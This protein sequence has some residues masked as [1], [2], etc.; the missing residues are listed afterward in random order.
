[1]TPILG[2]Y[3]NGNYRVYLYHDGTKVRVNNEDTMIPDRAESVDLN[4]TE[5]CKIV[6][7]QCYL[8]CTPSGKH[9]KLFNEDGS[10]YAK[11]LETLPE[12][13]EIAINGND[14][15]HPQL[16]MFLEYCKNKK[17]IVNITVHQKQFIDNYD[18]LLQLKKERLIYGIGVSISYLNDDIISKLKSIPDV[19]CH[20]I[21]G[22]VERI[23]FDKL[24]ENNLNILIL[25]YKYKGRGKKYYD[26]EFVTVINNINWLSEHILSYIEKG[27][28]ISFDCLA[29]EQMKMK[30][31]LS[32][33]E[34]KQLYMGEDGTTTFYVDAVNGKFAKSSTEEILHDIGNK[35]IDEMFKFIT[36]KRLQME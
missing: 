36:E 24:I 30:G 20:V 8:G 15:D 2:T 4:F 17:C 34:W 14:M 13:I 12:Y 26:K 33:E 3:K 10:I 6:C 31:K 25:G 27:S 21:A 11:W 29:C 35:S 7:A 5:K 18:L 22:I 19:V 9:A 23:V 1:M 32:T 28:I 16:R